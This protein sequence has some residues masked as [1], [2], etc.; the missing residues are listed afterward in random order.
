MEARGSE[1]PFAPPEIAPPDPGG[2]GGA[3]AAT[4]ANDY[5]G[6]DS[7]DDEEIELTMARVEKESALQEEA[8][9]AKRAADEAARARENK[10]AEL[11]KV[12]E[13]IL[14]ETST[15]KQGRFP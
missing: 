9:A 15:G 7:G 14:K 10:I 8:A 5:G 1:E 3:A 2:E 12:Q 4:A 11:M 6:W 13:N